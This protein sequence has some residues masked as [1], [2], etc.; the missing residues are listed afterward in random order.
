LLAAG[1]GFNSQGHTEEISIKFGTLGPKGT[2]VA[3][4]VEAFLD[5]A[6]NFGK[7]IGHTVKVSPYYGG[8]MGDEPEMEQKARIGQLDIVTPNMGTLHRLV[9]AMTP[10]YLPFL[11][12]SFGESDYLMRRGFLKVLAEETYKQG[13]IM[14]GFMTEG[15]YDF[16]YRSEKE[17]RTPAQARKL[18]KAANW[19]GTPLDNV[20]IPL[21]IP[22]VPVSVPEVPTLH[23]MGMVN[24]DVSPAVW[25]IGVQLYALRPML[26]VL[27]P[28][29]ATGGGCVLLTK[30]KFE[31]LPWDFKIGLATM[32]PLMMYVVNGQF[33]DSHYAFI[34]AMLKY[35]MKKEVLSKEETK[36][37]RDPLV[38]YHETY[39]KKNPAMRPF[40]RDIV[41][42]LSSYKKEVSPEQTIYESDPEYV[43]FP[44]KLKAIA[45][46]IR[47]Y[48]ETDSLTRAVSETDPR[49]ASPEKVNQIEH[50]LQVYRE[51]GSFDESAFENKFIEGWRVFEPLLG[52]E[53]FASTGDP[54]LIKAWCKKF[55]PD[56][57]V[58]EAFNSHMAEIKTL[59]GTKEAIKMRAQEWLA[60]IESKKYTGYHKGGK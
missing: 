29:F 8:V 21:G 24:A 26:T 15:M 2:S 56:A 36:A 49:Y 48:L 52:A 9:P 34:D 33:R 44:D 17:I 43:H 40:Y 55:L 35:G 16:Y 60:Y 19:S 18:L 45:K 4:A 42:G 10:Y 27:Q 31:K 39:L 32:L 7:N 5:A 30:G 47:V 41:N 58:D 59:L 54:R 23:K 53:K 46:V 6:N 25:V 14:L 20:Y 11:V 57:L 1:L 28:S 22:Q 3:L 12:N 37:W 51:T 13:F 38:A 50:A